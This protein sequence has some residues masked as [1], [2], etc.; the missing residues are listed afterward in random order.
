LVET[1]SSEKDIL[2]PETGKYLEKYLKGKEGVPTENRIRAIKL[3]EE[4]TAS[5]FAGWYHAM[6][7]SGGGGPQLLK[8]AINYAY[9]VKSLVK[10]AKSITGIED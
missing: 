2:E 8:Q 7:I 3:I 10:R 9:D 5:P 4:L 6:C 1:M